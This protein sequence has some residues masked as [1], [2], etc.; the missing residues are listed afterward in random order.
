MRLFRMD[1]RSRRLA[2]VAAAAG[3][4]LTALL[5][6]VPAQAA[7][8]APQA[9]PQTVGATERNAGTRAEAGVLATSPTISPAAENIRYVS[10]NTYDCAT[11]RLCARVW[12]PTRGT[13][14]V[15]DLYRCATY[16]LSYWGGTGGFYNYQTTGTVATFYNGSGGVYYTSTAR[17]T[18]PSWWNWDPIWKIKNC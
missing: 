15:F 4:V 5:G 18:A 9:A 7:D 10:G 3:L 1:L 14:K 17:D 16:S 8:T 6:V 11:G 12:D 2:G 13:Y